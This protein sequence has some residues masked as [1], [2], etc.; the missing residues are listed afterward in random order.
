M[1]IVFIVSGEL[2]RHLEHSGASSLFTIPALVG[3]VKDALE[4]DK[5]LNSII[6]VRLSFSWDC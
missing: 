6:K 2:A 3:T 1:R 5:V 4:T